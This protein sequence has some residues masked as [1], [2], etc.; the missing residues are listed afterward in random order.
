MSVQREKYPKNRNPVSKE[1]ALTKQCGLVAAEKYK[2]NKKHDSSAHSTV[3]KKTTKTHRSFIA[4]YCH[5]LAS[6]DTRNAYMLD[7][8]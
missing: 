4:H 7:A 2:K 5:F 8:T 1:N 3:E 6:M